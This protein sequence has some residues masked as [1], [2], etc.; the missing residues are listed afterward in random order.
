[1][2][3][4]NRKTHSINLMKKCYILVSN[5]GLPSNV[6]GSW[7]TRINRFNDKV[8]LF[9]YILSPSDIDSKRIYCKK[10]KWFTHRP[11]LRNLNLKYWVFNEYHNVV[12]KLASSCDE[13]TIVVMDDQSYLDS[14]LLVES[15]IGCK[16]KLI[17]SF[18]GHELELKQSTLDRVDKVLFQTRQGYLDSKKNYFQFLPE[19]AIVGNGVD[20]K[21]FYPLSPEIKKLKR[22]EKNILTD[23]VVISWLANDRPS[24]GKK[25]LE[26]IISSPVIKSYN[27]VFLIIG[28]NKPFIEPN[29]INVGRVNHLEVAQYLQLSDLFLFTS[30]CKEGF[31]LSLLEAIKC[32]NRAIASNT[33]GVY[34][35]KERVKDLVLIDEPNV[36]N[37]WEN[38][39]SIVLSEIVNSKYSKKEDIADLFDYENWEKLYQ[40][41][42]LS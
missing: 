31:P 15:S 9:D 40:Q 1:M 38:A 20:S 3:G 11:L 25:M 19:V 4:Y 33:G 39:M 42:I 13:M 28:S 30:L 23:S 18:H 2:T 24:K 8:D 36:L 16:I 5:I 6:I 21:I 34:A 29:V 17:Y 35:L 12:R 7:V 10:R 26:R 41:A 27:V 32:G 22:E 14:F 37:A